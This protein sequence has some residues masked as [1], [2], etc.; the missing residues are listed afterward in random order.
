MAAG[1]QWDAKEAHSAIYD[2]EKTAQLFCKIVNSW[3]AK[4][5]VINNQKSPRDAGF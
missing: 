1:L 4:I 3:D 5:G 2:A